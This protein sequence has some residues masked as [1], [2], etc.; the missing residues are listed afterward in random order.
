MK[1]ISPNA[2]ETVDGGTLRQE[3]SSQKAMESHLEPFGSPVSGQFINVSPEATSQGELQTSSVMHV[4]E[5]DAPPRR[6][7]RATIVLEEGP[8]TCS[9]RAL[10]LCVNLTRSWSN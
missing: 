8:S 6:K 2:L 4:E 5:S 9:R 1:E 3:A 10:T 7:R